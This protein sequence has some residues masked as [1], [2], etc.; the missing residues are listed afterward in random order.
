MKLL[1]CAYEQF[2]KYF[3][4]QSVLDIFILVLGLFLFFFPCVSSLLVAY[5]NLLTIPIGSWLIFITGAIVTILLFLI[6]RIRF[7]IVIASITIGIAILFC[8][9]WLSKTF[10]VDNGSDDHGYH[11]PATYAIAHNTWNPIWDY[12]GKDAGFFTPQIRGCSR[13]EMVGVTAKA[14][15]LAAAAMVS[16]VGKTISGNYTH[17][18]FI[19]SC[20]FL[21]YNLFKYEYSFPSW[22][23]SL[24]ALAFSSNPI[25]LSQLFCGFIDGVA[26]ITATVFLVF[27]VTFFIKHDYWCLLISGF[28]IAF[29]IGTRTTFIMFAVT[30]LAGIPLIVYLINRFN[31]LSFFKIVCLVA[32]IWSPIISNPYFYNIVKY[33]DPVYPQIANKTWLKKNQVSELPPYKKNIESIPPFYEYRKALGIYGMNSACEFIYA[34]ILNYGIDRRSTISIRSPERFNYSYSSYHPSNGGFGPLYG[35]AFVLSFPLLIFL[36]FSKYWIGIIIIAIFSISIFFFPVAFYARYFGYAWL[37]PLLISL[38]VLDNAKLNWAV[39]GLALS[40]SFIL[41]INSVL[42]THAVTT[43]FVTIHD[44]WL[45][46]ERFVCLHDKLGITKYYGLSN[47]NPYLRYIEIAIS[48]ATGKASKI[49]LFPAQ[50]RI[51]PK[52]AILVWTHKIFPEI[53]IPSIDSDS[54]IEYCLLGI[55]SAKIQNEKIIKKDLSITA[56]SSWVS[57]YSSSFLPLDGSHEIHSSHSSISSNDNL[58][59]VYVRILVDSNYSNQLLNTNFYVDF[60]DGIGKKGNF[61]DIHKFLDNGANFLIGTI[62]NSCEAFK[63]RLIARNLPDSVNI[64]SIS[65]G[66]INSNILH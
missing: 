34:Q 30:C 59:T 28:S 45:G 41:F 29:C 55:D 44:E 58:K 18:I 54:D 33:G 15:W 3:A 20:C 5:S 46:L 16:L 9:V 42:I 23:A 1:I 66:I 38:F 25:A 40:I 65:Y 17:L 39:S 14:Q 37:F 8:T 52:K 64:Q 2:Y 6:F 63:I 53:L 51:Q 26:A 27:Y 35:I 50:E 48:E 31:A 12:Q 43:K 24:L 4:K 60:A 11:Y 10:C 36:G 19:L 13:L 56:P 7:S 62:P 49:N 61:K 32:L 47:F 21:L 22:I 57:V